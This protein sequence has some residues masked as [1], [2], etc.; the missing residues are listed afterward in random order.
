MRILTLIASDNIELEISPINSLKLSYPAECRAED[1]GKLFSMQAI[2]T[3]CTSVKPELIQ[4]NYLCEICGTVR[5]NIKQEYCFTEPVRCWNDSCN[6]RTRWKRI[7]ESCLFGSWQRL[8]VQENT[9]AVSASGRVP[10][11][12]D[13]IIRNSAVQKV[14]SGETAIITGYLAS[15]PDVTGLMRSDLLQ[16]TITRQKNKELTKESNVAESG[17]HGVTKLGVRE[18]SYKL[19]FM[20]LHVKVATNNP[21]RS[22]NNSSATQNELIR[23]LFSMNT[24][25]A[26]TREL[27]H[28]DTN[29]LSQDLQSVKTFWLYLEN[30]LVTSYGI[31]YEIH[32]TFKQL[33]NGYNV[34]SRLASYVAPQVYGNTI[35]KEALLCLF[36]SGV[37]KHTHGIHLRGDINICLVG[38]PGTAKSQLL[39]WTY[40][41]ADL[42]V[43]ASGKSSTAAGLTASVHRDPESGESVVEV[44]A[45]ILADTGICCIDE[46]DKMDNK[47]R[48]AI[49]EAMEQQTISIAKAGIRAT[50][51][52][53]ASVLAA[54]SPAHGRY[55]IKR[56]LRENLYLGSTILSRFDLIFVILDNTDQDEDIAI[57][58]H[59]I[60]QS[61]NENILFYDS[62]IQ[63]NEMFKLYIKIAKLMRPRLTPQV[64]NL[65]ANNYVSVRQQTKHKNTN[66]SGRITTRQLESTIRLSEAIAKL[67]LSDE[68][69]ENHVYSAINLLKHSL[70][71]I[72]QDSI[73]IEETCLKELKDSRCTTK[74]EHEVVQDFRH[75]LQLC[76]TNPE[77]IAN[78]RIMFEKEQEL[79]KSTATKAE[80]STEEEAVVSDNDHVESP[81]DEEAFQV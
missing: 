72:Q 48:I 29:T 38:D 32:K 76:E 3:K 59:L 11:T 77:V 62:V 10:R 49:H 27:L 58:R 75:R 13:V 65:L 9:N 16:S 61:R 24:P 37:E 52:A 26:E 30:P 7:P 39:K 41:F 54:C 71:R 46:F 79:N 18:L 5:K 43:Y 4:A 73:I 36:V 64:K 17:V 31:T 20:G 55:D 8:V 42:S 56:S 57:A 35:I 69:L 80:D 34:L 19:L 40:S 15:V 63:N 81:E 2:V 23:Q 21:S 28:A 25:P 1:V 12:I 44:G 14:R 68:V 47:D 74:C 45:L 60:K 67:S 6:N 70:Y 53:R 51:N 78:E 66:G 22:V 50:M 33:G